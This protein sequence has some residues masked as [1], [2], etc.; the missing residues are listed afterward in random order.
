[1]V[2]TTANRTLERHRNNVLLRGRNAGPKGAGS[3]SSSVTEGITE[4]I[5][6]TLVQRR[7]QPVSRPRLRGGE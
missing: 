2:A 5:D 1:M 4:V 7:E 6:D 3:E